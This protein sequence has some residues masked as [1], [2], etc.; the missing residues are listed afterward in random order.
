[1]TF[2]FSFCFLLLNLPPTS[3]LDSRLLPR[4]HIFAAY[5]KFSSS[6]Y[7]FHTP[8]HF[9]VF[10]FLL[11]TLP[12]SRSLARVPILPRFLLCKVPLA[13]LLHQTWE[14]FFFVELDKK[15]GSEISCEGQESMG[16]IESPRACSTCW[17]ANKDKRV[18]RP[19]AKTKPTSRL[20]PPALHL[21]R[22]STNKIGSKDLDSFSIVTPLFL[23]SVT[24]TWE[25]TKFDGNSSFGKLRGISLHLL[26][27][28][29][30]INWRYKETVKTESFLSINLMS[31]TRTLCRSLDQ[32]VYK[33]E[34]N[35]KFHTS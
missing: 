26:L 34:L 27:L 21:P 8:A 22:S 29:Q 25:T 28:F 5:S 14:H 24:K 2:Q 33:V 7:R 30:R 3:K 12:S 1:M 16:S 32:F 13:A 18:L 11:F 10:L 6:N 20:S 35:I 15:S 19:L 17:S 9:P 23:Q 31:Q 4:N